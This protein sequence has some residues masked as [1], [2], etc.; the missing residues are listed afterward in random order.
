[1]KHLL[2][3]PSIGIIFCKNSQI[4]ILPIVS[5]NSVSLFFIDDTFFQNKNL[6]DFLWLEFDLLLSS[7]YLSR[8]ASK[9]KDTWIRALVKDFSV[10]AGSGLIILDPVDISGGYTSVK[11]KT[12]IS[13]L[14][15]D[16]CIHLSL[17]A[18]S[19]MLNLQ[20][21]AS[22]ALSFGNAIPLVQ[23]T[24]YDRIWV[25]EK[26]LFLIVN[27]LITIFSFIFM[28]S[29]YQ[30]DLYTLCTIRNWKTRFLKWTIFAETGHNNN[31]TFWRPRAP[32][33]YV[34]LG[35]C[36]TSRYILFFLHMY[37]TFCILI[38]WNSLTWSSP[39]KS[40]FQSIQLGQTSKPKLKN[41][42]KYHLK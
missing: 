11:D 42:M 1:M 29:I 35:D 2:T 7:I 30:I 16:I 22:A 17:S 4:I 24:N 21:Q 13:L 6:E 19:L 12:N 23:C 41:A 18:L 27:C 39:M 37:L 40:S 8:Y 38:F 31:I 25:S 28:E 36:V 15:T 3:V 32:A 14:S 9:E 5:N 26:G 20:S 34:I 33:N 10:E